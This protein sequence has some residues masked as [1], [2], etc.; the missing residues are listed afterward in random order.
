MNK[1]NSEDCPGMFWHMSR[2]R[3]VSKMEAK[4][5]NWEKTVLGFFAISLNNL[6]N[7]VDLFYA[8]SGY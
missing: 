8:Q 1:N 5:C 3:L 2:T 6:I 7:V 4:L